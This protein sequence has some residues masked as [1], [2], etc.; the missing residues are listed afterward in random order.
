MEN[1]PK[2]IDTA[3]AVILVVNLAAGLYRGFVVEV[4][5]FGSFMVSFAVAM[6]YRAQAAGLMEK[7]FPSS[8]IPPSYTGFLSLLFVTWFAFKVLSFIIMRFVKLSKTLTTMNRFL[9]GGL[10][11]V[12]GLVIIIVLLMPLTLIPARQIVDEVMSADPSIRTT[13]PGLSKLP[14]LLETSR[15]YNY[16]LTVKETVFSTLGDGNEIVRNVKM[17]K[18][19]TGNVSAVRQA[20]K[21]KPEVAQSLADSP[22][23]KKLAETNPKIRAIA[24][25]P[26]VKRIVESSSK[27]EVVRKLLDDPKVAPKVIRGV[28]SALLDEEVQTVFGLEVNRALADAGLKKIENPDGSVTI[29]DE[30]GAA[31]EVT[32][33]SDEIK[34]IAASG[35]DPGGRTIAGVIKDKVLGGGG[36]AARYETILKRLLSDRAALEKMYASNR[37]S[38]FS[39]KDAIKRI[40][41]RPDVKDAIE[42]GQYS[43]LYADKEV[44][45][46]LGDGDVKRF[47]LDYDASGG[48]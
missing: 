20:L 26:E 35:D 14:D 8:V 32:L 44:R 10:G 43:T 11:F 12:K 18:K 29:V 7:L 27:E 2:I 6:K 22:G 9:G 36:D 5:K 31:G 42:S 48:K 40:L 4:I 21:L 25:D 13:Y 19:A 30:G 34:A 1:L 45:S 46:L 28:V 23:L 39:K 41:D 15:A 33:S 16:A 37:F 17:V 38:G 3:A 24:E 47:L